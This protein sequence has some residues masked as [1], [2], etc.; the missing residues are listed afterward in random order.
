MNAYALCQK[1]VVTV[2]GQEELGTVAWIMSE[3]NVGCLVVVEPAPGNGGWS[4]VGLITHRDIVDN[5]IAR[6]CDPSSVVVEDVMS[7]S[8][9]VW[10][11]S[12]VEDVLLR[13][14]EFEVRRVVVVDSS[15]RMVGILSRDDILEHLS[16]RVDLEQTGN[17]RM[18]SAGKNG[19][20]EN[21][22]TAASPRH[23]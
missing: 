15:N 17:T 7:R 11:E 19:Y 2:R 1:S 5:V 8:V 22:N 23:A 14:R 10:A 4:P 3:R 21:L 12:T 6:D 9:T 20:R 16:Q 13:M 18:P